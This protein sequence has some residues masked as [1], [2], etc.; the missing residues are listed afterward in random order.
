MV[1]IG[2]DHGTTG[3]SFCL[4]AS[5]GEIIDIA[6]LVRTFKGFYLLDISDNYAIESINKDVS[7]MMKSERYE[8]LMELKDEMD[9][10]HILIAG[11]DKIVESFVF[12]AFDGESVQFICVDGAMDRAELERLMSSVIDLT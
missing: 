10:V 7:D 12:I 6:P 8:L 5:N 11:N 9:T 1:F 3:I 2:M 4:M